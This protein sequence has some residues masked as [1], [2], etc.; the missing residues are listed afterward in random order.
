MRM[1][2]KFTHSGLTKRLIVTYADNI[3]ALYVSIEVFKEEDKSFPAAHPQRDLYTSQ[4]IIYLME[5][6]R[7]T[8]IKRD[9]L[10]KIL[11]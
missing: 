9:R 6:P 1:K 11:V 8:F 5:P 7:S 10:Q 4:L 2:E 3:K